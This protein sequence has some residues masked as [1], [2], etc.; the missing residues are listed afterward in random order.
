MKYK[1]IFIL[2]AALLMT[3]NASAQRKGKKSV[4]QSIVEEVDTPLVVKNYSDSLT[5]LRQ[6]LDSIQRVNDAL[7]S[8]VSDGRYCR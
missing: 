5:V 3:V 4:K 1:Y 6:Q 7:R 8:E 2:A